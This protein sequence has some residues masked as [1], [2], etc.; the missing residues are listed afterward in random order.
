MA[1][2][3]T[4]KFGHCWRVGSGHSIRVLGDKWI[5][6][7]PSNSIIHSAKED[8]RD[9][10]V[11]ELINQELHLWRSDFIME[12]F[13]KENVEAICRIPL[14]RRYV[15]D[16][17]VWLLNKKGLF[18]VKSAYKV[19]R[20]LMRG[21][22]VAECTRGEGMWLNAQG[23]MLEKGYGLLYGNFEFQSK[24]RYLAREHVMKFCQR[25][26]ILQIEGSLRKQHVQFY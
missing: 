7:Y 12:V 3:P 1:V 9:A 5:P 14:S 18:T 17:I 25:R 15:E 23:V 6:N 16:S 26:S 10:L 22:N 24:L 19:A 11:S 2:L 21:R 8:L 4:L 13:E 20:E